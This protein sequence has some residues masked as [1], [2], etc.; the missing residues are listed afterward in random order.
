MCFVTANGT[1]SIV[2]S[3]LATA[4]SM[5]RSQ[6]GSAIVYVSSIS[7]HC[8][9]THHGAPMTD[10]SSFGLAMGICIIAVH[11]DVRPFLCST[12]LSA[13]APCVRSLPDAVTLQSLLCSMATSLVRLGNPR[14]C[15]SFLGMLICDVPVSIT[16]WAWGKCSQQS[17][18]CPYKRNTSSVRVLASIRHDPPHTSVLPLCPSAPRRCWTLYLCFALCSRI[19]SGRLPSS[20]LAPLLATQYR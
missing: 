4:D 3:G 11:L 1:F 8:Y 9:G 2:Q 13:T 14:Y 17:L 16:V 5:E 19:S 10:T 12:I 7:Q 15:C 6:S 18:T 20:Y